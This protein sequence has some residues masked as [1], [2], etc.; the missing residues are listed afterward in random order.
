MGGSADVEE[1]WGLYH[2][3]AFLTENPGK[4]ACGSLT[5]SAMWDPSASRWSS[6]MRLASLLCCSAEVWARGS[7]GADAMIVAESGRSRTLSRRGLTGIDVL[8]STRISVTDYPQRD[9]V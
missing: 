4:R 6:R 3:L 2:Y 1:A 5:V 8:L 7:W 9:Q